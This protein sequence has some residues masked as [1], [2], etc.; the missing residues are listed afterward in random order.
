MIIKCLTISGYTVLLS[1]A[2][3]IILILIGTSMSLFGMLLVISAASCVNSIK[4][5]RAWAQL[6]EGR[7]ALNPD[8]FFLSSKAF[9]RKI[10]SV[11][12]KAFNRQLLDKRTKTEMLFKRSNLNSNLALTLGY[13]NPALNN[14]ALV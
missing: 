4:H 14:P 2:I 1:N 9:S 8:F 3:I 11:I 6:F 10:F 13:L 5:T 12:F 7:L